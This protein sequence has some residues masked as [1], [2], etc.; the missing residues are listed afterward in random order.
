MKKPW[1]LIILVV[2]LLAGQACNHDSKSSAGLKVGDVRDSLAHFL[3]I[4]RDS[5]QDSLTLVKAAEAYYQLGKMDSALKYFQRLNLLNPNHAEI[6]NQIGNCL[7]AMGNVEE[8][9][10]QYKMATNLNPEYYP[11]WLNLASACQEQGMIDEAVANYEKT[12]SLKSD[13][14]PAYYNLAVLQFKLKHYQQA[15]DLFT[16]ARDKLKDYPVQ[17]SIR[18][19]HQDAITAKIAYCD[20]LLRQ[21][22]ER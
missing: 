1:L 12:I 11:A 16:Q 15:R 10:F 17:E 8:A 5:P 4:L 18:I 21:A 7:T 3:T 20:S 2:V 19:K 22:S 6:I 14:W 9:R 13:Y